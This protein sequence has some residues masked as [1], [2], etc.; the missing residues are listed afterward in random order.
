VTCP[1]KNPMLKHRVSA[2]IARDRVSKLS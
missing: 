1:V 2:V